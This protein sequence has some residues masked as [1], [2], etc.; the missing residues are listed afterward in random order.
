MRTIDWN[1]FPSLPNLLQSHNQRLFFPTAPSSRD[2]I[3]TSTTVAPYD[4]SKRVIAPRVKTSILS[5][6]IFILISKIAAASS[7]I[8]TDYTATQATPS[9][10]PI[11]DCKKRQDDTQCTLQTLACTGRNVVFFVLRFR[12][13]NPRYENHFPQTTLAQMQAW[14]TAVCA[15]RSPLPL[16]RV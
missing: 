7:V 9:A 16:T 8:P 13:S 6:P 2:N 12:I 1:Q 15:T 10:S 14:S 3:E 11:D 5:F 4:C